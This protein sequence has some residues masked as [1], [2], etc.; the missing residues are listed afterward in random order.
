MTDRAASPDPVTDARAYQQHILSLLGDDDPAA[1]QAATF[2]DLAEVIE[3]AGSDL[4]TIPEPGEWSV[5]GCIAHMTDAE[6][7]ASGRYRWILTHDQPPLPGY[8]QD[9]WV[10]RLHPLD[11]PV[12]DLLAVWQPLRSANLNLWHHSGPA[13]RARIGLHAERG[14]ESYELTFRMIAGHD[15]FHLVQ[16]RQTLRTVR[17]E[18]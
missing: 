2:T 12:E 4:K 11:E 3:E 7:A 14:P 1:V 16:A 9:L 5:W 10:E 13:E 8:D 6:I 15:R 18:D 17:G